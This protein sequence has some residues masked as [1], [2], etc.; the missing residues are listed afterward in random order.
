M[1]PVTPSKCPECQ[2][3]LV[4][5]EQG[6]PWCPSCEWNLP[7]FEPRG[8]LPFGWR[9]LI[10]PAYRRALLQ[11]RTL[12]E[13]FSERRPDGHTTTIARLALVAVSL[14]MTLGTLACAAMG[15]LE[16]FE[17]GV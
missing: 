9:L 12:Y 4:K 15:L 7:E 10:K 17:G 5:P 2:T 13:E 8:R 11:D 6:R 16:L 14:V 1:Q 3:A